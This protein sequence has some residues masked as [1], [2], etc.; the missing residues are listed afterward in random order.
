MLGT[1]LLM[2]RPPGSVVVCL[3]ADHA[4]VAYSSGNDVCYAKEGYVV[5]GSMLFVKNWLLCSYFF[6]FVCFCLFF[7]M[8]VC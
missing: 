7:Y 8:F 6:L 5:P 3:F 1:P 4:A 2:R